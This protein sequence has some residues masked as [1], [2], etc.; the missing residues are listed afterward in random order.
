MSTRKVFLKLIIFL[1]ILLGLLALYTWV[2]LSYSSSKGSRAG[3]LQKFSYRGWVCK[4]W[5]GELVTGAFMG[6]Q[7]KFQFSVRDPELAKLINSNIGKR[8]EIDYNQHIGVP[9]NC[10]AETEY[11]VTNIKAV[12]ENITIQRD[13]NPLAPKETP[14]TPDAK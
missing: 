8:V 10:F 13:N 9:T 7:E 4:T 5:E 14:I 6:N 11:Y 1:L 12:P 2:T 3:F